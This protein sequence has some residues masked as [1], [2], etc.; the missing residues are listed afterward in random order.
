MQPDSVPYSIPVPNNMGLMRYVLALSVVVAHFNEL[1]GAD[2]PW[3]VS[4]Y[5]GV[6]GFFA[7]SGF[8]IYGS[9]LRRPRLG[10]YIASRARRLLPAY[11]TTVLF[12][13][14]VMAAVSSLPAIDYFTSGDFWAYLG[15]NLSFLNFL[16][17][18]LPG[19]FEGMDIRAVNGSLWTMKVEWFLYLSVPLAFLLLQRFSRHVLTVLSSIYIL[20]VVYRLGMLQLYDYGG[21]EIYLL[22]SRQF[23]GQLMFFYSGVFCYF[24]FSTLMRRRLA[25]AAVSLAVL[26]LLPHAP[27]WLDIALK[28]AALAVFVIVCSMSGPALTREGR[29]DNISYNIYLVHYPLVQLCAWFGLRHTVGTWAAFSLTLAATVALSLAINL[30][31]E[32]PP[33]RKS[34]RPS[35]LQHTKQQ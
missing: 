15:A 25:V 16:H 3:P 21:R 35:H 9:F 22:L 10:S 6:G 24:Y 19:V 28:P 30:L 14:L 29:R 11:A 18:T 2:I 8:L 12:F 32:R 7:L 17:P 13:A 26:L 33:H 20:S 34:R 4:S 1:A 27:V 31:V 23:L 5:D